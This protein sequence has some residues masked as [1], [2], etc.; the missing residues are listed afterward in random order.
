MLYYWSNFYFVVVL[1]IC[2]FVHFPLFLEI[3]RPISSNIN[4]VHGVNFIIFIS[5]IITAI[6]LLTIIFNSWMRGRL[7]KLGF[8]NFLICGKHFMFMINKNSL[9]F[10]AKSIIISIIIVLE[11]SSIRF[12]GRLVLIAFGIIV[13]F[14]SNIIYFVN[15]APILTFIWV[16]TANRLTH[17]I[18]VWFLSRI[19]LLFILTHIIIAGIIVTRIGVK[20]WWLL[21]WVGFCVVSFYFY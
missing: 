14:I 10:R 16:F 9:T 19:C 1:I 5:F 13:I 17:S 2:C 12:V 8:S 15:S 11:M 18:A 21:L 3:Q 4:F 6:L 20:I 7:Q